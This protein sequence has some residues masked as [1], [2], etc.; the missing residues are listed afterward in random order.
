MKASRLII[1]NDLAYLSTAISFVRENAAI[2]G[3][4]DKAT[5]DIELAAEEAVSNVIQH[6]FSP[7]EKAEFSV[8]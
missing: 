7:G 8:I 2:I 5:Q 3:F 1:P 4:D 6:A